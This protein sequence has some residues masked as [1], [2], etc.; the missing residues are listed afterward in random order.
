MQARFF[1]NILV[2]CICMALISPTAIA[3]NASRVYVEPDGWSVGFNAGLSDLWGDIGTK[4]FINHYANSKY[5]DKVTFM[6]GLF[7]RYTVHPCFAIRMQ[8]N[9]GALYAT[10]KWNI[11]LAKKAS[12]EGDDAYQRYARAQNAKDYL[13]E[14]QILFEL[15]PF[16]MNP[17]TRRAGK[18]GQ[19]FIGLGIGIFHFTPYSTVAAS[20]TWVKTYDLHL[21][22]QGFGA[23]YPKNFSLWQPAIP[24]AIGYRWDIGEHLNLGIEYM[25]RY[26]FTDYLDGV[27]GKYIANSDFNKHLSPSKAALAQQVADKGY[28]AGLE[29]PNTPGNLR[30]N[31][32]NK[33]AYS[34]ITITFAYK[35]NTR[36]KRWW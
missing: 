10:D 35:V 2:I 25:Y 6:G 18:R 17:E 22:G 23:G 11:D 33:D 12:S 1:R 26:T 8:F 29:L 36:T 24:I 3:Q 27:S 28:W 9:Y 21:E 30:G 4:S 15:S 16:R 14:G 7:G 34:T 32:S 20:P 5:F 31:A 13:F 19:P